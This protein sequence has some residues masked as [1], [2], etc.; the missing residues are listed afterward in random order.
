MRNRD[1]IESIN[2]LV[3]VA[4]KE[5]MWEAKRLKVKFDLR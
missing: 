3:H 2:E 5:A 1:Y 4:A